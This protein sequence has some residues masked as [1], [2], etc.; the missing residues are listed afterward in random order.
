MIQRLAGSAVDGK[1]GLSWMLV[2]PAKALSVSIAHDVEG[3]VNERTF[4]VPPI[5]SILLDVGPGAWW[6]RV[7]AWDGSDLEGRLDWSGVQG[8]FLVGGTR[9]LPKETAPS[10]SVVHTQAIQGGIRFHLGSSAP[11]WTILEASVNPKFPASGTVTRYAY[12]VGKGQVE[13][14]GLLPNTVYSVRLRTFGPDSG[15]LPTHSVKQLSKGIVAHRRQ[16]AKPLKLSSAADT[17]VSRGDSMLIRDAKAQPAMRFP[18]HTFYL[19]HK[20]A[21]EKTKEDKK[22]V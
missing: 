21:L 6:A 2:T 1:L 20:A 3:T 19:K 7:G 12:D 13:C 10:V 14:M 5:Q 11:V 22:V 17:T 8:P 15:V 4:V 16:I 18:S 9:P